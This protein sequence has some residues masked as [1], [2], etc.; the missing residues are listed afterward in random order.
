MKS[1]RLKKKSPFWSNEKLYY[2]MDPLACSLFDPFWLFTWAKRLRGSKISH[3]AYLTLGVR[4]DDTYLSIIL[5][6]IATDHFVEHI[7]EVFY[8]SIAFCMLMCY[9]SKNYWTTKIITVCLQFLWS[10]T[11]ARLWKLKSFSVYSQDHL[12]KKKASGLSQEIRTK[13]V[14][15]LTWKYLFPQKRIKHFYRKIIFIKSFFLNSLS[16][17]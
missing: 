12:F 4:I 14:Y 3:Q 15:L 5:I 17:W 1:S 9:R 11:V 16:N 13:L 2:K 6:N 10:P 7:S 8:I